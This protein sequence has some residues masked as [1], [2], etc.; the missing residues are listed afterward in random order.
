MHQAQ[1]ELCGSAALFSGFLRR[2]DILLHKSSAAHYNEPQY[3][4]NRAYANDYF[5]VADVSALERRALLE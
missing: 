5:H 3:C 2:C 1:H 4:R